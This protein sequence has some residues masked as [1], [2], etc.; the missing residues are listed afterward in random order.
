MLKV[1]KVEGVSVSGGIFRE[2]YDRNIIK[3]E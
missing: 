2:I 3:K 1:K